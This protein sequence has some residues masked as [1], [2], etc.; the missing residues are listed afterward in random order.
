ATTYVLIPEFGTRGTLL[1][2]GGTLALA[3]ALFFLTTRSRAP[4]IVATAMAMVACAIASRP[5]IRA[6]VAG[7]AMGRLV[8]VRES[9]YQHVEVRERDD[10]PLPSRVLAIDEGMDAYES[11]SPAVGSLTGGLYFDVFTMIALARPKTQPL[12]VLVLGMGA[13]THVKQLL[14]FL[15][16]RPGLSIVGVDLDPTVIDIAKETLGLVGD[17]R[18]T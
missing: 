18:L 14:E 5:Q 11:V 12:S 7:G 15:G 2:A 6:A 10:L 16:E 13:G 9:K 4:A 3:S 8:S 17:P 1:A